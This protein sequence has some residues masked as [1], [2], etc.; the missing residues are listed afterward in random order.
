MSKPTESINALGNI[1]AE[2]ARGPRAFVM[3]IAD[4][5]F[6]NNM[7]FLRVNIGERVL[8]AFFVMVMSIAAITMCFIMKVDPTF[9]YIYLGLL[10]TMT[11]Y[12]LYSIHRRN[13][14]NQP[15]IS[16]FQGD[17]VIAPL[18]KNLPKGTNY[19]WLES[20]YEPLLIGAIGILIYTFLDKGLGNFLLFTVPWMFLRSQYARMIYRNQMFDEMD[21]YLTSQY[22][23]DAL[24]GKPA[25]ETA[26]VIVKNVNHMR[27]TQKE[28]LAKRM[29][30]DKDF[31]EMTS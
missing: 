8:S 15:I 31:S 22:K 7:P 30:G 3:L 14:N 17:F 23:L 5:L 12:H 11:I 9:V 21:A 1:F 27:P 28:A 13:K 2:Y 18:V 24:N 29:L 6:S 19:W 16:W 4:C 26:G 20:F 10:W 25:S